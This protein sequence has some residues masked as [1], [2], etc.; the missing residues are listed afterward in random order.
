MCQALW[1]SGGG[2]MIGK[3]DGADYPLMV[4]SGIPPIAARMVPIIFENVNPLDDFLSKGPI[5]ITP[6]KSYILRIY[7]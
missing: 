1:C 5:G 6:E 3:N 7:H 2:W 4:P